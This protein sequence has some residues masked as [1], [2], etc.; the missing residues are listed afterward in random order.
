MT[1]RIKRCRRVFSCWGYR[2]VP[3]PFFKFPHDWGIQGVDHPLSTVS[4]PLFRR[5]AGE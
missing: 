2:G 4:Y 3:C 5:D 1:D